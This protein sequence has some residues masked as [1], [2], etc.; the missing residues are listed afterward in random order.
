MV[1]Q[2]NPLDSQVVAN[3]IDAYLEAFLERG[4]F[5]GA[6]LV[7]RAGDVLLSNGYGMANLEHK[8]PNTSQ[9]KFR[10]GS[11]TKQ[12]T[13]AAILQVQ[14]QGLLQVNA[15]ISTYLPDYPNGE[16]SYHPSFAQ[17]HRRHSRLHQLS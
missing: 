9:T 1:V 7:A 10:I 11:I 13:A 17:S 4:Y 6:G 12:F 15:P 14:E 5:M 8:A 3:S 2:E 16:R